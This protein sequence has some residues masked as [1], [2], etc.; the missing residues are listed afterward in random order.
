MQLLKRLKLLLQSSYFIIIS[1]SFIFLYIILFTKVIKYE[2]KYDLNNNK[3]SGTII[4][5]KIDGNKLS[6]TIKDKEKVNVTYY[7]NTLEEKEYLENNLK[8]GSK[9]ALEGI[10]S[11]PSNNTIP[12]TFNYK[13]YLY[14]K[15][16]YVLFKANKITILDTDINIFYQ[17]KNKINERINSFSLTKTYMQA[18]I[19]GDN[20]YIASDIYKIYQ[21]NGVTH[22]FAISG[23]HVSFLVLFLTK[24][25]KR[26]KIKDNYLNITIILFLIFYMFLVNFSASVVRASLLYIF[27]LINKK[28][29]INLKTLNVLYLLMLILLIINPF[30]IYDL[31][32]Q[33]SFMTSFG[34]ILFSKKIKGNY[35]KKTFLISLYAFM[36]SLPITLINFYEFNLITIINNIIVVPLVS[37]ILFPF[38]IITFIFPFLENILLIGFKLL[39]NINIFLNKISIN[40]IVPKIN[41]IF[42][43][44]YYFLIYFIFKKDF[45]Y[46]IFLLI[47]IFSYKLKPILDNNFYVC[48][49][50]IGQGDSSLIISP[51]QKEVI[52]ID[53]G[54][55]ITYKKEEWQKTNSTYNKM[56]NIITFLKSKG[57]SK[58]NYLIGSHG[59]YDHLGNG[60]Y[61]INN[62][63]VQKVI[64]NNDEFNDTEKN[65]I[66]ELTKKD[67]KYYRNI[68]ELNFNKYKMTFL[69][70]KLYDNE[71]DNSLV[72]YLSYNNYKF[73]FMGDAGLKKEADILNKYNI[74]SINFLK[75]GHHGSNTSSSKEFINKIKPVYA[76]ISVGK[77]NRYGHPNKETLDNLKDSY[78]YRTDIDGSISIKINNKG[79]KIVNYSP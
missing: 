3:L 6:L 39:E 44:I 73:L 7:I 57:I 46:T 13:K 58:I 19:L 28:F 77:N 22:L 8:L 32:F 79:Y 14:N 49:L 69:N 33:Y 56:A 66:N 59:D 70:T 29:N 16:I 5:Q 38:T 43:I 30:Y 62:F 74:P 9:V 10:F 23:M 31:G 65:I 51:R 20:D 11:I 50:D 15:K 53:T 75:V 60:L 4:M 18:F 61:L 67:I 45:K 26:L 36:I 12:N 25:L 34:L 63:Q 21:N 78:I 52:L 76:I 55:I 17:I 42:L 24:F 27:L 41:I 47:L 37:V 1:L 68:K 40:I 35:I 64:F 71:N 72:I 54:G 48:Y 2:T